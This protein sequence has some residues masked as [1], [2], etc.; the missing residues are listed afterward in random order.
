MH[1]KLARRAKMAATVCSGSPLFAS[2]TK[3]SAENHRSSP[4]AVT[5]ILPLHAIR[6]YSSFGQSSDLGPTI[7]QCARG[8]ILR[9]RSYTHTYVKKVVYSPPRFK[10]PTL[11]LHCTWRIHATSSCSCRQECQSMPSCTAGDPKSE[12][13]GAQVHQERLCEYQT[14]SI[15]SDTGRTP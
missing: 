11:G 13:S 6:A 10:V 8:F 4:K 15:Y 14:K 9:G 5:P 7:N 2:V 3:E 1:D 12:V